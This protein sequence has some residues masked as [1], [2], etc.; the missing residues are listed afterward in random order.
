V[1]AP[2]PAIEIRALTKAFPAQQRLLGL[3]PAKEFGPRALNAIDLEVRYGEVLGVLGPNGAGKTTLIKSLSALLDI[4]SGSIEIN[5]IEQ[6]HGQ[7]NFREIG[8]VTSDERSFYW[9]LTGS[10]NLAFFGALQGLPPEALKPRIALLQTELGLLDQAD[11][12]FGQYSTGMKQRL[13]IA[14]ALLHDP[15]ILL[16][17]EPSRGLDPGALAQ[18][19][20][21]ISEQLVTPKRAVVL[22]THRLDEAEKICDRLAILDHGRLVAI[23]PLA[24]LMHQIG[25]TTPYTIYQTP[26]SPDAQP[27]IVQ[28]DEL[29]LD[30]TLRDL[31]SQGGSVQQITRA[32]VGLETVFRSLTGSTDTAPYDRTVTGR[33]A[34]SPGPAQHQKGVKQ[35]FLP[36]AKAFL[37]RDWHQ[38]KSY[39]LAFVLQF[40]GTVLTLGIFYFIAEFFG[41]AAADLLSDYGGNYFVFILIGLAFARYFGVGL[42]AFAGGIRLAQTTGTLEAML[43][44]ATPVRHLLFGSV[45]WS[46]LTTTLQVIG[47]LVIALIV[48]GASVALENLVAAGSILLLTAVVFAGL[49]ILAGS[50]IMLLK[51]GDPISWIFNALSVFLGGVYFP[52]A[53][54]P[55]PLQRLSALLPI[56]YGLNG[57]RQALLL[58]AGFE[59][60][61]PDLGALA[62]FSLILVP[63]GLLA[64]DYAVQRAKQDGTLT[65][66]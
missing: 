13:S 10:Q 48:Q 57:L 12:P 17:D 53:I 42:R 61:L 7:S 47:L 3:I 45:L 18:L 32:A 46:Y 26:I 20:R 39:P 34:R 28:V 2:A 8:I 60:V 16:L 11:K 15:P 22:C 35:P 6:P 33:T 41:Q 24:D 23:G 58:G 27:E 25:P 55:D 43:A 4:D 5:G 40:G 31:Y 37:R 9:R 56:T 51:R 30:D 66:Y 54:L 59:G 38:E 44:T 29:E 52:I 21:L 36:I 64:F 49:G 65:H 19:H 62:L 63:V 50:F 1:A 14:R